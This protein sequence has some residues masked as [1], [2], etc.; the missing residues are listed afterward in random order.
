MN[1]DR[2]EGART[3]SCVETRLKPGG[4]YEMA[5]LELVEG[6]PFERSTLVELVKEAVSLNGVLGDPTDLSNSAVSRK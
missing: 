2:L 4:K 1:P 6:T 3:T 5:T